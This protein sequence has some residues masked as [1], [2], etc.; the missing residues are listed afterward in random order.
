MNAEDSLKLARRFIGLPLE[1]RQLFLQALQKE[2]VEFSRFPIP[3][4]VEVEDRQAPSYAQQ[5]MWVLWQLDPGSGAYNL[6]G[7]V[8][9][10]GT[11][12]L[13]ALEQA[14][15]SLVARHET[16]RTVFRRQADERLMQV[17]L[18]PSL[19]VEHLDFS[20]LAAH[21]REQAV[22]D[23]ATRQSLLPFDLEN[24]P[25]LRV[26]LLKLAA[27]E[28][29]L[30]L[31]LHH[32]VSD[33]WSM[34]VLIDEFI[35]C[36]DAH[37]RNAA[38]QLPALPIQYS[39]YALWQRRWLEA[40]E[41]ARQLDYWR[42]RL[43]D[44][45]P[46]L[47][48]PTDRPRPFMPSYRGARHNFAI[49]PQLAAQLR[50][51]AQQ[52]NVTLFMLLL[53]AFNVL[54]HRYTGQGDIRVGVPIANRNRTEVEGLIGFFVN[55]QVLRTELTGQT[56]VNDLLQGI[57]EHALG[58][59][60]HQELPFERLVEALKVERSLSHTPLFQ[61]MYN[62]QPVVAD[63]ASVSTASGLELALVE[64]QGR[65]TQFDL[66]LD[67]YETSG[68][69]HAA[70]TYASDLFDASSIQ[71]MAGHW[72]RLLQAMV[73]DGEQRIGELPMLAADEQQV[74]VH[75]WNQTARAYPT[76][77]GIHHL[78]EDQVRATP[79]APAL[80]FGA[81]TLTYAQL[82]TRAN[83]LAHA[84]REKGVGPDA[85]V[86]ICVERSLDMV[87]G[88]LA[89]L[90][91]GGA[92][93]PLDPEYPR[94]RLNYMIEDSGIQW[95]LSQRS[96]LPVLPVDGIEVIVLDQPDDWLDRYS[97]QPPG[98]SL[99]ALNLAYVI[100]TSGSTGQPKGAGNS[101]RALVNR[102]CWMQ[103]A[104]GLEASDAVLQKTP[105]S[106]DVS[107]W[108][109]FW[110]LMTGARLVVAAPGEH[111]EPARLIETIARQRITTLHFVPSMLQA[112][113]H[114]PGVQACTHLRRIVCSGEALAL[115]AQLQVFAK[116]PQAA[117]FNLYGP[118][119]AAIDVTHWTCIDEGADNV[120]IGRPIANLGTYVLDA[121]L[122]PVPAG[123]SGELYLGGIGL[124]RSYHRR[125]ALTA[126][127]FVPSP[128]DDGTRLYRTGDRVR[129][130]ADGVIE[131]LGRLD[132]QVKLRGLRIELGEIEARLMQHP[133][134]REA[135]VLVQGGKQLV[136]YLV[137]Q[138]QAPAD[139]KTW[140]L[141][142]LPEYMVPTHMVPLAKLPVTA[143]GKLDRKALP[144]PDATPQQAYVAPENA[145]QKALAAIW[146]DV[147]G[148][149]Q[150]GL[151]DNFFE[152]GGDSIISIQ[153]VSRA[154]QAGIRLSPRDLFQ[155]QS[156]RSLARVA[157]FEQAIVIDQGPITGEVMLTPVQH[158]FFEQAIP[159]RHH[160]NQSLLLTPRETLA[161]AR[162]EA[163]LV[164]LI[165]HHDA[166]RLRFVRH[167]QE[168]Q[169][170]HAEPV[171]TP[172]LWQA[173]AADDAQLA[174]R[175]DEA[176][177]SLDLAQGPL[178]RAA[179]VAMA[180]GSQRLLLVVH[181]LVVDG[182]SWR[183]LLE[184]LQQAYRNAALPAK[185]SAYQ[186]WAQQLQAHAHTL[187]DQLPYW[188]AQTA[189]ADLPCDNP[190]GG[191]QNRLGSQLETRLGA[192]HTRQLLQDAPAAYRT[193]VNDLLLTALARVITRWS[194]Q[195]AALIQLEGHGREDLFDSVDLSRSVGWFTSL[196]P[197]R[198]EAAGE[199]SSAIKSV[200]EQ[201]R[202]VPGKGIG[203]GLLRYLGTPDARATLSN[204]A[205]PRITFN[206]LGQF[207]RQFNE[208]AL[209]V[210]AT[211]GSGQA[212][213][214]DAPL[215]NWL[216]VEGQVYGGELALQWGFSREMFEVATVQRLADDY[217]AELTALIAHCC[218]TPAGQV[219]PSDFPLARL[220]Q[221]Q[222]DALPL[223]GPAI[224]DIYPLSP[225]QQGMLFHTLYEPE[226]GAYINQLRLDIEGLD[227]LVFGRAWQAALDRHDI[228][229]SSF[230]WLGLDSAH[231]VIQ[232]QADVQLHVIE[233]IGADFD[234]LA[235]AE[236]EKG[237]A[238]NTAP[239][240]RL[241]LVRGAGSTWHL[242]FT[243]HHV[244]MDGWSNAQLLGEVIAHYAGQTVPAPLGQF[245]DYLGWLQ[246]QASGEEFWKTTLAPLQAPTLLAQ[247]LRVP[248]EGQ[249][250]ADHRVVLGDDFT[251][252]LGEFAR[253]QKVT[254]NTVLQGAWSLLLQRYTGQDCVVFGAT[255]AGR[256]ASLPGIEQQLGLFINTLPIVSA[257]SPAL[258]VAAWLE[259][260]QALNLSLRDYEH[261]PLYDIQGWAG[262]QGNALFDTLLVFEN[263]PVAEA[264]KQGAPAGLTFDRLRNH[265]QTH[266]P[267]TLGIELGASLRLEF[268]YDQ[269]H[270]SAQQIARL[271]GNLHH[272]L[273]QM[274]ANAQAP[275]GNL[276]LFDEAARRDMLALS[277]S[278]STV[279]H[280]LRV[281]E[282][283]AAQAAATPDALAVQAGATCLSYAQ[284]NEQAN[285]LAHRLL[286]QGVGPGQR[287]G[288]AARRGPQLIVSLLAV[289][290]SGAAYV[291]LDPNYPAERLNFMLTDSRLHLLLSETGLL[292]ELALPRGL[293]RVDFMASGAE[294]G[295]Y[296]S[297]NPPNHAATAD[298][299]Y[300]I[301][302]SG[303][304]GLPKGVAIDHAALG[305]F[306]D[307]AEAYSRL[308]AA[309]RVLLFA[310]FSFDGFVEQCFP[311]LC[312]GAALIMRGDE[313][314]DAGQ[315][316]RHIVEQGVTLA[317]L[318]AA[319]WYLLAKE[320]AVDQRTLGSLR[321]VHVGGEAMSVQGLRAWFAAGL[322]G[323]RLVNTYG[324]TE[325]TVVSSVHDCR[326][327][328]ASDAFGVPIGRAIK[329][330]SLYVLDSGFE[331]L[332]VD[333]VG[334]LC[335]G[336]E[337]GLAQ[338]YF[339][340][341]ALTAERFLPDPFSSVPGA[342]LYRSGDL[343]RYNALGALEYVGRID[344]QVKI[345]GFRV[346]T[347]EIEA[348]LQALPQLREAAVIAQ[349]SGTGTQLVAYVV[350]AYGQ[351][352]DS[353]ALAATLR[354][355]LPDY[356]VPGHWVV[357]H[358]LPLNNSGKLDRR[359]LPAP[360]LSQ[361]RQAYLAPRDVLQTR[362]AAIWQA[363]L[364]VEIVGLNDHFFER[365]GHSL[366]ATQVIS[367]VRHEL[368]LDVP[369]R[370]L[371][372]QPTLEGF[373]A[374]CAGLHADSAPALVAV[375]RGQ[376][377][378]LSFAQERQWFL[379]QLDPQSAAYHVPSALHL[380]G[381]LDVAALHQAFQCL[382]QRHEP[383]RT[384][385]M[386]D[387][388]HVW[389]VIH[390]SLAMPIEQQRV[391]AS[392]IEHA[393]AHEIQRPFDLVNGPLM[394][395]RLLEVEAEHHVLVITQ[396]HIV[397]D[398]WSMQVMVD[399]LMALYQGQAQ[400]PAL[401]IQYADYALW[402]RD[403]MA[404]G[405]KQRQLDYWRMRLG[406]E[407]SVLELPLDHP[408]PAVQSHRGARQHIALDP[409]LVSELKALALR[410]D[411]TLFVLLL[412]SFQTLLHRYSGQS[413]IRVGVP[414]AN[415]NRL[416]TERLVGFFVNTQV[417]QADVHGH[418]AFDQ[419]LAQVKQR[420]LE[421]QAH[422]DLP[423]EQ[424]VEALQPERSLSHNPLF[425]VMFNHQDSLR[426]APAQLPG[427]DFKAVDWAGQSTQFDLNLETEESA[428][429][430]W[431]SLT[432]ATDLFDAATIQRLAE[433]WQN[434]LRAVVRDAAQAVDELTLLSVSQWHQMVETWND[435]TVGY[436][437]ERCVH[438][439]IEAQALARPDAL[440]LR[441]N[442]Q[443]LSYG[444]L[445]RR[446]NRL[447]HRLVAAGV[448]PDVLVAVHV[449]RSLDMALG[450]L[451][452]LKAGGAYVPLDPQFPADRLAF[453]LQ[454][455]RA[456][457]LLTQPHLD[458]RLALSQGVQVLMVDDSNVAEHDGADHNP[459]V[460]VS[461]DHLAYVIY[462]SG[463]T[464]R[465]KGVMVRHQALCSFT[466]GM[467]GTLD[468][469]VDARVLSL[470]T[471]SFD[472]FAL[473]LYVP[474]AVGAAVLLSGQELA[475]DPQAIIDRVLSQSANVLQAT[476]S[477]WRM[478]LESPH[479]RLLRGIKC[480]CGGEALSKDLA[481]RM[482]DLQGPVWNL[483]GPTETTIWSAAHRL[484][485][486]Q[487]YVGRPIANTALFIL[488]AG[489]TPS[490][491][492]TAG[493]LLIGGVGLAR[494]YHE[495]PALTAERFVPNPYGAPGE[496]LYRTGDLARYRAEGVVEYI[497]RV[498]HQ[499]KVRGFRIELGEI[500]ACL[501]EQ[502]GV[503]EAVVL[504][505][506]DRLI[507]YLVSSAPEAPEAY[508]TALRERLPD[509][510]VPAHLIFLDCLPL[511][512][513]GKLDRKAL[514]PVNTVLLSKGHVAPVTPREQQVAA[515]WAE[516]L[517]LP[518][519]GLDDHFFELG[520]HS[521]LAT[522]VVSRVRQAL[523]LEVALKTLF[524]HPLLGDFVRALGEEGVRA[525]AMLKVDRSQPLPL[526]YAQERQWFLWQLD[527]QS[528]AYHIPSALRLK[529]HLD[530]A[531]LQRSFDTLLARHESLRTHVRQ[532]AAG[533][534]Q[535][536]EDSGLIEIALAGTDESSLKA[537]VA[538][539]VA[540]PFELLRGPL[541]R[542]TLLRLAT[543]DH[544][545]VLVQHHIVSDGW[546]MQLMVEE[547][548]HL[549]GAFS[550]GQTPDL[551]A[552]PIQYADYAL[553]Q[554]N[555]ME[556]GEKA[557]QLG[558]WQARLGGEQPVLELPLDYLRPA[559]QSHR[560]ARLGIELRPE[561][562]LG[563][564]RLAQ[565]AGVTLPM[566][567]L[568]SYQALLH[569]YS[570]Q[571]DVRVGVP[572]A[573]RN[574]LETEGLIGF[575]VNTQVLKADVHGQMSV[576]QLL[577][578]VRQRS[579]EAQA[580]QD[581]PFEQLVEAL[582]PERSMSL[583][584]LFQVLF[585]HRVT[586]AD[587]HWQR[588]AGLDV[589]VLNW[590]EGVAQY[591]LALDVEESQAMLRASLS[592]ATDLFAPATIERMAGHWQN[593]LQAMVA[594]P[595]QTISQ[596]NLLGEDEQQHILQLWNQT[597]AGFSSERL[598]HERVADRAAETPQA[599][600]VKFDAQSLTYGELDRQANRLAHALIARG[601]SPEV[602]VAIAMPRSAESLVA[603][604]AVMKAGGVYVPL[605][606]EY[607]R[608][609]LLYMMQDSR[610]KLLLTHSRVLQQLPIPPGL[611]TLAIDRTDTW[612]DYSD[613]APEVKLDGD[614]LA[615]V[616][617]TSGSTG[618]PK[619]VAVAHGPLVAHIIATGE[620][621]ETSPADCELH[622]MSFAFDG[623]HEGWMHPL[624]NGASVLIRDDSLWLPEYTYG[625]MHRHNVTMAV[626]PPVYLQQLAEHAERDGNPPKVRVY[627]FGGDAVA[628]A[629]YDLAWR[630]LKPTYL[631]NGYGPTE[632]VVTPLLWKA[633]Q[634]DP[635][636]AVYAP[637]GT[638]LGNRSGYVLDAHLNLQP[639]GV[640]GELYLGGE[641]VARGYLERAALTAE[642][643]V[644]DPFG[645]PGS[646][647]YRSGDLTRGRA[648][649]VVD[650]LGRVDHQVKIRGFRIELGEIE[651]R[652]REQD[653]VGETVVVAQ[654]GPTGKQLVAYVVPADASLAD[655]AEFR[656]SLRRAL[657]TRL[658]DY[659]VPAHFMFLAQM[660]LTPNGKLDRK[661]LPEPDA[662][663]LQQA[664]VAP[665]TEL[666]QQVAAI[667]AQV[668]RL[669]QVGLNDNFF[670][671][672]GHSLLAIQ[673]T[674]R[675]Q[676]EL[677]L[678]VPL[679]EVFHTE[680]LRAY[681][682]AAA[683]FRAGSAEDF[684][685]LRDFLSELEAI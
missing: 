185:T 554:R 31:T 487:P 470:T 14:F 261:V 679:V 294:L 560:G 463:S 242:I 430:L 158:G 476:P 130:R 491:L 188:Q 389:Q 392:A 666:E 647:V 420:A 368:K 681:V 511:T 662:S 43:G 124:A 136:A 407:H 7:A 640:A 231:Q 210:P 333:G 643:F 78:I 132:H 341:P 262:H 468:I 307:S 155:Y 338:G 259:A 575:F 566:V 578:Q 76:E 473:E 482:L 527:P 115:D 550:Q 385:F 367:R 293:K 434:L 398:G 353:Q 240:F 118:T 440:A 410:Q 521:L 490:P 156:I 588:L 458:G 47:E 388:E 376:P 150:I 189:T 620:R 633:R 131:Y 387:G 107:V 328:D 247:A 411:V 301:Y 608:D 605:D 422:Q 639:I 557:R 567:L 569:R 454:D 277:Q 120:P 523:A 177:R 157:T 559:V 576:V 329:G 45:H 250:M 530:L 276:C 55:T 600:A 346:E 59:Q 358:A 144:V 416:E 22:N 513:N 641:G 145:L 475:L 377:L 379:W 378:V 642:R 629:S 596:L 428:E 419:L 496:R 5:R 607:P 657:K 325:A 469:G 213:D 361:A 154:R 610:A 467:A 507:A 417:L 287:V 624:I 599:V 352:L 577:Q 447:A 270:F 672:G 218:A 571:E 296:P 203:Y 485:D 68:T 3:A 675:V 649:G 28:H 180:D 581:L 138:D 680:T 480:L 390:P 280:R 438:H 50:T 498:D 312:V 60:A 1:K 53:G 400:L 645:Q 663:L 350:P 573:N 494:G 54:L 69:L 472:I 309:D 493:E 615:Y 584:P 140:L 465:P 193:Q 15:A 437:R 285:R 474:L 274:L 122:N 668:L 535:V 543:N 148:A 81:A 562:L 395:I 489:L 332:A 429:G 244:L 147:L 542:V 409:A 323:V 126:E 194:G 654:D 676:A 260:L 295:G 10:K 391:D 32:I 436:P 619:G 625:Q 100:Y 241:M 408:R 40:G 90:K 170:T 84:L 320:C 29:V 414:I 661:G 106:F 246:Q 64:W 547:L 139:L 298:L 549:Y 597:D 558:Y 322:G 644:P 551:P 182:V 579:L 286:E 375:P 112:F 219:T 590:D 119:E 51:C 650:Y 425:Q 217:A 402:Q 553:W 634:G 540:Q 343:A 532:D 602:R 635:C 460:N 36:Y 134:V 464:G 497:G 313:L 674:S 345:R 142:S 443:T 618:M 456:R 141:D 678:E 413:R 466:R 330:R 636:G 23:A 224:A 314:W 572:I 39:D 371:F 518:R 226:A 646:R 258:S 66:T 603:F 221:Q 61:V 82:D 113:I 406:I 9:L 415:R 181:H 230:H 73:A 175:C 207:D 510:M 593:L 4:G 95:L 109:F 74:L 356:M 435:T 196:F 685:D 337:Q 171:T 586:S 97:T 199:L 394:R 174:A 127:R 311:P 17:A 344:H 397:S 383:L 94:D 165:N 49:D 418:L 204:L 169:Q 229:R 79:D 135:V 8:R 508:K 441:F 27:R 255:V 427:L 63:I 251:R 163:A 214:P 123:V 611:D 37:E 598:V 248:A 502:A 455:S 669:P 92:Y 128:F 292:S 354:Q 621:Y 660:P 501:R 183:I 283:I 282:R 426:A 281:H 176:Q 366:L 133:S 252:A 453:M 630:A 234:A 515:I 98:V 114:E 103:Q 432:Y 306:C 531:A 117:L 86:G 664:Y 357:L 670:E 288:L 70:L 336:A 423:F 580:H 431:A 536:I 184:D 197:V 503:R 658:P 88:L 365:G 172:G 289:L 166:L 381:R 58:A 215:A 35:R 628:Q 384:T 108:E 362:L 211:Q 227:L 623:A 331:L 520:G 348:S 439:L 373:A 613:T 401:P 200:K 457:V 208:S 65:T 111:R 24:G 75:A 201:L 563:L 48:L 186:H 671:V 372:E 223:G 534:V 121:Q 12:D 617:Y 67:T 275:L 21:E 582:Q 162:L 33:G 517:D 595:Q 386:E 83:R 364:Q 461:P 38:P 46:V 187:D 522:R 18:E 524:E 500:E 243:S 529:G 279:Q 561:L 20:E 683:T 303:S 72:L 143:N 105:F 339:D 178:L 526:S 335:I 85:L 459:Q 514:P 263:F 318:P 216:T 101:H 382:V 351:T 565:G 609:R 25:L 342:R 591:D 16:L 648:D 359:A 266:Y 369:L 471:F 238:L 146:S 209:F 254:L 492:G 541:L 667:W 264:L 195:P 300:V 445:N 601:V 222:L 62:H 421:A 198:L 616:I 684:D 568:A 682:Q 129:Q 228:L 42:A 77:R 159:A 149:P 315:L 677:G 589:N 324:P 310:T 319:Y 225:M 249:G 604:L 41:Q 404:A 495:R 622:F 253:C 479:A 442:G 448:G 484:D 57:K 205:A 655:Q 516:V 528:T 235:A 96:L 56:R 271:S 137:L 19:A 355:S 486:T 533:T 585:N 380:R 116:L 452:T 305:Q 555:W 272:L 564:R 91:A 519:V 632:T 89:I 538:E 265:E 505:D 363:V 191:L 462:T 374:A 278:P 125:A 316:S 102:L 481:Q 273:A 652:L 290:K 478:L 168:W 477:T 587:H 179:L 424:L 433:H 449:E 202:A 399:E 444:E 232:R 556:T 153:V 239:L 256:S 583:S 548:V 446:A 237:F 206:Y 370:A 302:T 349:S 151:D 192:E 340:R 506:N 499:V 403:W 637:I 269:A 291:P 405:E 245:R 612:A 104:Y 545:L 236:R 539:V 525:P 80:T 570:G 99:H 299:A 268:G 412:A 2:G 574:R 13:G 11:L 673:I 87:V 656:D 267:L 396:H 110:P 665:E 164:Q 327:A 651:A 152:L 488:N 594:D 326:L 173:H 167:R 512:P 304:T 552:L 190:Q 44:E 317:D 93:V 537:R 653:S 483:Y 638:L 592:Y 321:Q 451:A 160:W 627:C 626:F 233:D 52:H 34:N 71:R 544:V 257:A 308:S 297:T 284:L 30:L 393:V 161:P 509:Y 450:L 546:S 614:N 347:G 212:Q 360:D 504:A 606:I 659:M 26:Q 6:P 631:F 334:E 220:T